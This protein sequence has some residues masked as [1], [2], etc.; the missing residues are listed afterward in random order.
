[1]VEKY[2]MKFGKNVISPHNQLET[3]PH[4]FENKFEELIEALKL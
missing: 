4:Y 1:M 3:Q 2:F